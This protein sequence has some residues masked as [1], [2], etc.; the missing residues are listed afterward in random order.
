M[1]SPNPQNYQHIL[2]HRNRMISEIQLALSEDNTEP[3]I[4]SVFG[5]G[6]QLRPEE[7][8]YGNKCIQCQGVVKTDINHYIKIK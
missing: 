4:C 3:Y 1:T 6:H 8:L 7:R 5:C 2:Y